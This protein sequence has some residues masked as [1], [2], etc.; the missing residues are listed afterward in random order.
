MTPTE[1]INVA[2]KRVKNNTTGIDWNNLFAITIDDIFTRKQWKFAQSQL[3]YQHPASTFSYE[4]DDNAIQLALFKIKT[5]GFTMSFTVGGGGELIPDANTAVELDYE[6]LQRFMYMY[7]DQI[8]DGTPRIYTELRGNDGTN[9]LMIGIYPRP[10]SNAA[11][12]IRGDFK[13]AYTID[14]NPMPIL[15]VQFHRLVS[16]GIIMHAADEAGQDKLSLKAERWYEQGIDRLDT[17]D[18]R[19]QK[20]LVERKSYEDGLIRKGPYYPDNFAR[21]T[22]PR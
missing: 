13:P 20:Y 7:P 16:Y 10:S 5:I 18:I 14:T 22:R 15:P 6:P 3:E 21:G 9:G 19:N 2:K 4:L 1:I 17:W 8:Q 12:Y 11:V